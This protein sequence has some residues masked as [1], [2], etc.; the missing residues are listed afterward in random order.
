MNDILECPD[1]IFI[2]RVLIAI[3]IYL[4]VAMATYGHAHNAFIG[5]YRADPVRRSSPGKRAVSPREHAVILAAPCALLWP[6]Y[7]SAVAWS[8]PNSQHEETVPTAPE[9]PR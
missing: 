3:A 5:E 6:F 2:R 9:L 4:L 1:D 8:N 7:W